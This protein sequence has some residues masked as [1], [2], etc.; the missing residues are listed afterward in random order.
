MLAIRARV[1]PSPIHGLGVFAVEAVPKGAIVSRFRPPLDV[2][3]T[4]VFYDA[5]SAAE[6]A[7]LDCYA[8]RNRFSGLYILTGDHDRFMNH[9][10]T[11]NVGLDP[12]GALAMVAL[13][14]LPAGTELT[15]DYTAFDADW[16]R[17]LPHLCKS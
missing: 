11:P 8:Y 12:S 5:L 1:G 16:A 3:F 9:S 17:K 6:R 10:D 13:T 14:D 7:F 15:C 2:Q 4:R